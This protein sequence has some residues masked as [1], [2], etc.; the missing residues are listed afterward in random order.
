MRDLKCDPNH[1]LAG[2]FRRLPPPWS[3]EEL[4]A[5]F[6]RQD[7]SRNKNVEVS[8]LVVSAEIRVGTIF[9]PVL[10][11]ITITLRRRAA[12][13]L[14]GAADCRQRGPRDNHHLNNRSAQF[15]R[16]AVLGCIRLVWGLCYVRE[17][18]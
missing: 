10:R 17:A 11:R 12:L 18:R 4:T 9:G 13:H 15:G 6:C 2:D 7:N 14:R 3:V 16:Y 8:Y 5:R 1:N